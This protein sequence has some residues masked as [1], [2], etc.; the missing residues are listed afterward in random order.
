MATPSR[1]KRTPQSALVP[2]VVNCPV[3]V[4]AANK[5]SVAPATVLKLAL[6][7]GMSL[8]VAIAAVVAGLDCFA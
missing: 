1:V 5:S 2:V 8:H 4:P 3:M 6:A 7:P